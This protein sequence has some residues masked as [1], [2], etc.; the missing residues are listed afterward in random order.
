LNGTVAPAP[1]RRQTESAG[2]FCG[3]AFKNV[4]LQAFGVAKPVEVYA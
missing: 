4:I 1:A 2:P 3:G